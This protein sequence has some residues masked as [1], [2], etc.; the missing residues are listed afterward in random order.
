MPEPFGAFRT[1]SNYFEHRED[2][3]RNLQEKVTKKAAPAAPAAPATTAPAS[4][5]AP[6]RALA[7]A[8]PSASNGVGGKQDRASEPVA[9]RA[10]AM[11]TGDKADADD[12]SQS[13]L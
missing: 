9:E 12:D 3:G 1:I 11:D 8:A 10:E 5:P 2:N 13:T 4:A 7:E 6:A